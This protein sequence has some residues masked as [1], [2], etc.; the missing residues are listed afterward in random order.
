MTMT[1]YRHG[2][3]TLGTLSL[4]LLAAASAQAADITFGP[5]GDGKV[6]V[7]DMAVFEGGSGSYSDKYTAEATFKDGSTFYFSIFH[8]SFG[9]GKVDFEVKSRYRDGKGGEWRTKERLT[10][11]EWS[12]TTGKKFEIVMG[13]HKLS[14]TPKK[15]TFKAEDDAVAFELTFDADTPPWRPGTGRAYFDSSKEHYVDMSVLAPRARVTG[16]IR[17]G[18]ETKEVKG[19]GW[20]THTQS[21]ML[22]AETAT[23]WLQF[24]TEKGPLSFYVREIMPAPRWGGEPVRWLLVA[25]KGDILFQSTDF[26]LEMGEFEYDTKHENRYGIPKVLRMEGK[27][28]DKELKAVI[29]LTGRRSRTDL[30]ESLSAVER[31]VVSR[32][33]KPVTYTYHGAYQVE[34]KT[35]AEEPQSFKGRGVFELDHL[36]K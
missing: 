7:A 30:L 18:E 14:G 5:V 35:G 33:A 12:Q 34:V 19:R 24:R 2:A 29:K 22:P 26:K 11:G 8:R 13:R 23:R 1:R 10:K 16:T 32:F 28:G 20:A 31:A 6:K 27:D 4:V 15:W 25:R 36:N 9:V 21:N 3:L 17:I